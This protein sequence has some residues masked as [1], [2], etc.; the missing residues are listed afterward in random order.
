MR[1]QHTYMEEKKR[2]RTNKPA[3]EREPNGRQKYI[4]CSGLLKI[5]LFQRAKH[6]HTHNAIYHHVFVLV[7]R[8]LCGNR[9]LYVILNCMQLLIFVAP[10]IFLY[11]Y[12]CMSF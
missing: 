10:N 9:I 7:F 11:V 4:L 2:E 3:R 12:V 5:N 8:Y 6:A 1:A